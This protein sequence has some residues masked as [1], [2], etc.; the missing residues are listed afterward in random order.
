[1]SRLDDEAVWRDWWRAT[2]KI[3]DWLEDDGF[4]PPGWKWK[5]PNILKCSDITEIASDFDV[6]SEF[7]I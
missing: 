6:L 1:V 3:A 2:A 7:F 4:I 5:Y